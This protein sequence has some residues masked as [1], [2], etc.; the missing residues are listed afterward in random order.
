MRP[1]LTW[2]GLLLALTGCDTDPG[3]TP[4]PSGPGEM[5]LFVA[6]DGVAEV[7][8]DDE[9]VATVE[10]TGVAH[11]LVEPLGEGTHSLTLALSGGGAGGP[12]VA[13]WARLP[14][15]GWIVTGEDWLDAE[16]RG[17]H[18]A[19]PWRWAPAA[20]MGTG[21]RWIAPAG[22]GEGAVS[23]P[24]VVGPEVADRWTVTPAAVEAGGVR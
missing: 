24:L 6:V 5:V 9:V 19:D 21:A 2:L 16:D 22:G 8:L 17:G 7:R 11:E 18:G 14:D 20:M 13:A 15:G 12:A 23:L 3:P 10:G 1:R 4:A